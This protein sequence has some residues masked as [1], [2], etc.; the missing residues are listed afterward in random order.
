[1]GELPPPEPGALLGTATRPQLAAAAAAGFDVLPYLARAG[2]LVTGLVRDDWD[3]TAGVGDVSTF[4]AD[5]TVASPGG[6]F[7][8]VQAAITAAVSAGGSA[9]RYI[10]LTPG[11]YREV[12]CV[13]S[14][15]P[16][17]T[18]FSRD[19][20]A[21]RTVI[22]FDNYSGKAK[23]AGTP[24]NPCNASLTSTTFGTSGSATF[25]AFAPEFQAKN[26]SFV[27]DAD[28]TTATGGLQAVALMTQG[29]RQIFENVR[30]LGN[31]DSL[32]VRTSN[33][34]V[35]MRGYFKGC[36]IE[37]D[38]DFIFGR[39]TFVLD[40]CTIRSLTSRTAGGVA[41]APSTDSRN[42]FGILVTRSNFTADATAGVSSTHL[43]RAWDESQVDVAT[44]TTNVQSGVYPNGQALVREST[45][46]PHIQSTGPWR[47]AAT[48]NRAY[49]SVAGAVPANRFYEFGNVG[50]GS[51]T[52]P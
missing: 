10:E 48:T 4:V 37:G 14:G 2:N 43:G 28:E 51:V 20:D 24:A 31:Q 3:P 40:G 42:P 16:P 17:L 7:T 18:L 39:A 12:V 45:L 44:Y 8:T 27:N 11:T 26:L 19:A 35:V 1:M 9:R 41:L 38:T 50:P 29:D 30:V 36:F 15:S 34:D 46:G 23:E 5:Y 25:A 33:V 32:S 6:T 21:S 49:S 52:V 13:P 22:V 47:A